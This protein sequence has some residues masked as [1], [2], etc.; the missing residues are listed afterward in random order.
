[1]GGTGEENVSVIVAR[2]PP[3]GFR[4][5]RFGD[6]RNQAEWLL[7]NVL[8]PPNSGKTSELYDAFTRSSGSSGGT[9][10]KYY[11]FEYTIKTDDWYRHNIAVF[12][13]LG[14]KLYTMVCK[15]PEADWKGREAA[16]RRTAESFRVFVPTG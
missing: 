10:T 9:G 11:T 6:A 16:F 4:L 1:M 14:G 8:A 7:G 5:D 13:E 12:A 15:V 3:G 2:S